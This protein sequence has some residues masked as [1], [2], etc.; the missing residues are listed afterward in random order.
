MAKATLDTGTPAA[1]AD[2][3]QLP[4]RSAS[5][6][7]AI[8]A[9]MLYHVPDIALAASELARIVGPTGIVALVTNGNHHLRELDE[10]ASAAFTSVTGT[11]WMA[12][13]RSA[14]RFLLADV[15]AL[16]APA[17]T[18]VGGDRVSKEIRLPDAAPL[19]AYVASEESL[20]DPVLPEGVGWPA[21]LRE[22]ETRAR[23]IIDRD[24]AF[25]VHSDVG[26]VLCRGS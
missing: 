16:I 2:A 13:G 1:V 17:L 22:V 7:V 11:P 19:V 6:D 12:P 15:P 3:M 8:A 20:Y 26:V 24:G 14:A 18:V 21:V 23:R 10:I 9:H 5:C 25:V 4:I